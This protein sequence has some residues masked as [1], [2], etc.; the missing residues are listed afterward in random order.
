MAAQFAVRPAGKVTEVFT[1]PSEREA[2]F[3]F[4][5][6]DDVDAEEIGAAARRATARR[7]VGEQ[8]VCVPIDGTDLSIVD[9]SDSRG[10]GGVGDKKTRARGLQ[11]ID[12]IAT[13]LQGVP[14]GMCAQ[15]FW[16][17][18]LEPIKAPKKDPR[19]VADKETARW[20]DGMQ[21]A[22]AA[23][24]EV[25]G[26]TKLWFQIDRGGDA[27]PLLLDAKLNETS[28]MTVRAAYDRRLAGTFDGERDYLWARLGRQEPLGS[29]SLDVAAGHGRKARRATMQLQACPV[30]L[31]LTLTPSKKHIALGLWAVRV[32]EVGTTPRSEKP[33]EWMLLTTYPIEDP[34]RDAITV[35]TAYTTRWRIEEFHKIWKSGA[36]C[37]EDTQLGER[38]HIER[39]A[40]ISASVAMRLL[41][42][43]YLSRHQPTTPA[44]DEL[45]RGEIDAIIL[46]R[47]PKGVKRGATPSMADAVRWLADYG[48]YTGKS[49]GGPPG[50]IVIA[51]G[52]Q[53]IQTLAA[54]ISDGKL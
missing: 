36:C 15:V 12:A 52:L 17:R 28:W 9:R 31:D 18:S 46:A 49:S 42:L 4:V 11:V 16:A 29:Y 54:V 44:S 22:R 50:A 51:R 32:V 5:E 3:R 1:V 19:S 41:R 6:N 33:I 43:V 27:W 40:T 26:E 48:G 2:A 47:K 20:L 14:L 10:L 30:T 39:W 35:V 45:S 21:Q 38:D 23:F 34:L 7:A 37:I 13:T 25:G 8:F 53:R 24:D